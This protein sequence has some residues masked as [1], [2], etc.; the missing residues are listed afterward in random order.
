MERYT[1]EAHKIKIDYIIK[2][3]KKRGMEGV[4]LSLIHI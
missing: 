4:Y 1:K 3:L 2:N